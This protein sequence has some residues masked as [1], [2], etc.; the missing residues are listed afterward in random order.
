[1]L[2]ARSQPSAK[3]KVVV[4]EFNAGNHSVRR[5]LA[6]ALATSVIER[7]GRLP[8][9][10]AANCLQPDHQNDNGWD[11]GLLFLNPAKVWLQPPGYVTQMFSRNY[12]PEVVKCEATGTKS[13]LD[14]TANRSEDGT[15]LVLKVVN[16]GE[17]RSQLNSKS[18]GLR[19]A[20]PLPRSP[21]YPAPRWRQQRG[22]TQIYCS[23]ANSM[24]APDKRG[25]D[26]LRPSRAFIHD[27]SLARPGDEMNEET[28]SV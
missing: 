8:I 9:V 21:S 27:Y 24:A 25:Q 2:S 16:V 18:P 3:H 5:A 6:N 11:Q 28:G 4:F 14:A 15:T 19:P 12:L 13:Q 23:Q 17:R 20:I 22:Q 10:T 1:M 26:Q 7:D